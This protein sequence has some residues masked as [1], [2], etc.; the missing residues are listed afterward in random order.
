V[1]ENWSTGPIVAV[2]LIN[3]TADAATPKTNFYKYS[4]PECP[5]GYEY[6]T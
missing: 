2:K 5:D 6:A 1:N 3:V 4:P